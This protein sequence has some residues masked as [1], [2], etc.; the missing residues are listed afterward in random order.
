MLT[1]YL[2]L[3]VLALS[4]DCS[5]AV[6]RSG[7]GR[8]LRSKNGGS[9]GGKGKG[10]GSDSPS[11]SCPAPESSGKGK[12]G[13]GSRRNLF[14]DEMERDL[15]GGKGKSGGGKGKGK[16]GDGECDCD[17]PTDMCPP[18]SPNET[19]ECGTTITEDTILKTSLGCPLGSAA[20][21]FILTVDGATLECTGEGDNMLYNSAATVSSSNVCVYLRNGGTLKNCYVNNCDTGVMMQGQGN[22]RIVGGYIFGN[23]RAVVTS[24]EG[25]PIGATYLRPDPDLGDNGCY[26]IECAVI[27]GNNDRAILA[28]HNGTLVI[29]NTEILGTTATAV[30]LVPRPGYTLSVGI[31]DTNIFG[32]TGGGGDAVRIGSP[33]EQFGTVSDLGFYGE[34][35]IAGVADAFIDDQYFTSGNS[36]ATAPVAITV[37]GRFDAYGTTTTN[38][39]VFVED[40][41]LTFGESSEVSVCQDEGTFSFDLGGPF[42]NMG[43]DNVMCGNIA[44]GQ[45]MECPT[46]GACP[47]SNAVGF[48]FACVEAGG[49]TCDTCDKPTSLT[50]IY[51]GMN[52]VD[53]GQGDSKSSVE[54]DVTG[55]ATVTV[56]Y[57]GSTFGPLAA[58]DGFTITADGKFDSNTEITVTAVDG[59]VQDIEIHTSCS[60]PLVEGGNWGSIQLVGYS[61]DDGCGFAR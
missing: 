12:G 37:Y 56:S 13:K 1:R 57:E 32:A 28:K 40:G 43:M 36:Q 29:D 4:L 35:N 16:S 26:S 51:T 17:P 46:A 15:R 58:G 9:N 61:D 24:N 45:P 21:D 5:Q 27:A 30:A 20:S 18:E 25:D 53:N 10:K 14:L 54:G 52:I 50:F 31:Q 19:I 22:N 3:A 11:I 34:V 47:N 7:L 39:A 44:D 41:S 59:R 2:S 38:A 55:A 23:N 42:M 6:R 48:A 8:E 60:A 49:D 33:S